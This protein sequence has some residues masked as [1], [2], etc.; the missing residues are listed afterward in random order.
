MGGA[1]PIERASAVSNAPVSCSGIR[2]ASDSH[3]P[4]RKRRG[5]AL[6]QPLEPVAYA[7]G[8]VG[9]MPSSALWPADEGVGSTGEPPLSLRF[10]RPRRPDAN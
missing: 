1:W 8:Y 5:R 4:E 3:S 6:Q 10:T 7:P 2:T 9:P